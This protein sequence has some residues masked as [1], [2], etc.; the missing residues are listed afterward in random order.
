MRTSP[1]SRWSIPNRT[2]ATSVRPAPTSPANPTISPARTEKLTSSNSPRPRQPLD[3]EQDVADRRLDLR[4]ERHGA[5]D[6]VPDQVRRRQL[7]RRSRDDMPA[8][9]QHRRRVAQ[10]EDLVQPMADEQDRDPRSRRPRTIVNSRS[11]SCAESDAVGSSRIRTCARPRGTWRSRSAAGRPSTGRGRRADVEPDVELA[12]RGPA[13]RGAWPASR[14]CRSGPA[15]AWPMNTFSATDRSGNRR[16]SWWTTAIR[17]RGRAR[18]R[19][20][21]SAPR[22]ERS[23]R[24]R[25]GGR[26]PGS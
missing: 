19:G 18:A 20:S 5:A 17:V 15:G 1:A 2:R 14:R 13:H 11:T 21:G 12:R 4:E 3:L 22:R 25:A 8:V 9:A 24:C 23:S 16:G 6:H 26:R 10:V 7:A